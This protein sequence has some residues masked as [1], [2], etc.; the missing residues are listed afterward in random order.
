MP[1]PMNPF[2]SA[3]IGLDVA[4]PAA[5]M[6]GDHARRIS[7][8]TGV[9]PLERDLTAACDFVGGFLDGLVS[10]RRAWGAFREGHL[11]R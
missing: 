2:A 7:P 5:S 9:S 8:G 4:G 6:T 10:P 11:W 1:G 3:K